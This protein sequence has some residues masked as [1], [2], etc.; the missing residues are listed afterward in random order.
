MKKLYLNNTFFILLGVLIILY[1]FSFFY[2]AL[3]NISNGFL[4]LFLGIIGV[5]IFLLYRQTL[6]LKARRI[7]PEKL[8]NGDDNQIKF[9]LKNRYP[10]R[11]SVKV[12]DEVPKQFQL[13]HFEIHKHIAPMDEVHFQFALTPKERGEYIFGA[14]NVFVS[15][16]LNLIAKRYKFQED[17]MLPSYPSFIHLQKYELLALQNEVLFGGIKKIRK[18]GHTMEFEQIKEYVRGDD[19]R[20]INW[21]ATGKSNQLMVNQYQEERAQ[22][23]YMVIDKG[24]VMKMPFNG[25]SLLDYAIN[26]SM[27]LSYIVLKKQDRAGVM[28]FSKKV[29]N[30]V[31]AEAKS[32]QMKRIADALY[33]VQ[34]NF[35]ESDFNRLYVDLRNHIKQRSL[36][37]LF[38]NFETQDALKR[39]L[40]YLRGL[41]KQHLVVVIFFE[42]AEIKKLLDYKNASNIEDIYDEIIAEKFEYEKKLIRQELSKYGIHSIYTLPENLNISVINKYLEIKAR[43]LI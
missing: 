29:E 37:L 26:A 33:N 2:P 32:S 42:N 3:L 35:F 21:K 20:T 10:F 9:H 19:I 7:V 4:V 34:T 27:A 1:V 31:A 43:G 8:S 23:I 36:L 41:A 24:R 12:I 14:L 30:I 15:S 39:Q 16:P 18:I 38:T 6:G 25:L 22:R 28:T 40:K 11:I 5:D 13:R 17:V